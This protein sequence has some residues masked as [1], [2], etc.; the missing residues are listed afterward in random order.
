M[1]NIAFRKTKRGRIQKIIK[2]VYLRPDIPCGYEGC[3]YCTQSGSKYIFHF[4][5]YI[6]L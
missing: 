4:F 6:H 2:E 5:N 1:L 3:P